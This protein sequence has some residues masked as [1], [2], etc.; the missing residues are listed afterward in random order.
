VLTV[1]TEEY[2]ACRACGFPIPDAQEICNLCSE[3]VTVRCAE[4]AERG[5]DVPAIFYTLTARG[6][7]IPICPTHRDELPFEDLA[8]V[9]ADNP[10][11]RLPNPELRT[12]G[13]R[14]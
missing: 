6:R 4:C 8:Y 12:R 3:G 10:F 14:R 1:T 9:L 2:H 7:V 11:L 13:A 5:Q